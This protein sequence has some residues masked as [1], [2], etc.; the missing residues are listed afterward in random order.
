[1]LCEKYEILRSIIKE[2]NFSQTIGYRRKKFVNE[3]SYLG[4]EMFI[5]HIVFGVTITKWVRRSLQSSNLIK[6]K[7]IIQ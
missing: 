2:K 7:R 6:I 4:I 3:G 1:M 5:S